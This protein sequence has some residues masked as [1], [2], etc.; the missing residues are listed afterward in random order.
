MLTPERRRAGPRCAPCARLLASA[1]AARDPRPVRARRPRRATDV[2][3]PEGDVRAF[4]EQAP[5]AR[6]RCPRRA[7]CSAAWDPANR[8]IRKV[9]RGD[10]DADDRARRGQAPLRRRAPPAAAARLAR[11][12]ALL[13]LGALGLW[14]RLP[15]ASRVAR[16]PGVPRRAPRVAARVPL[17]RARGDRGRRARRRCRS[18]SARRRRSS[19]AATRT[20]ATSA[21]PTTSRSSPRAAGRCSRSGSFYLDAA[22]HASSGRSCNVALPRRA[23][24]SRSAL[25]LSRPTLRLKRASTACSSSCPWAV[26]TYVTAL[27]WKGMFHRQFGAVNARPRV[28]ALGRTSSPSRG[29]RSFSTA[30]AANVAT[31]VW[32]GFPFMM[33]VTLG[34][35]TSIPKDVLEAAEV[36]GATRWQRFRLVTLPLLRPDAAARR[37]A[38]RGLD[39]QHVQRRLPRLGRRA[40]RHDRHP[41]ERGLPLGL[42]ARRAV[43]LRRGLRGAHLPPPRRRSTRCSA[44][45]AARASRRA[46][47]ER[48][49]DERPIASP[50]ES[51]ARAR[52]ARRSP[53]CFALYP[54]LWVVSLALL[55]ARC[56]ARPG[57][58]RAR[59]DAVARHLVAVVDARLRDGRTAGSS[60]RQLANSLVVSLATARRRRRDRRRPPRTRS[61]ASGSSARSAGV[62]ALLATQMFPTVASAVPLYLL[63]DALHLLDSRTGLV[64]VLRVDRGAVRDLPAARRVRGDPGRPRGGGDGRRRDALRGLPARGAPRGAPG[65]RG[66]RAL[67]LHERVERVHPRRDAARRARRRSRCRSC[68][69]ATS[70]STTR[71]WGRFAAGAI[72]VSVPVMALFYVAQRQLV[73]RAHGGRREGVEVRGR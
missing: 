41:R 44:R 24:A 21:S 26:P 58:A 23:S 56:A 18:S 22:R 72:L 32:L 47:R 50:L 14:A 25:V 67:R 35:L 69:S 71:A 37:R 4:A 59:S 9:L 64:L 13:V 65:D 39:V 46:P 33:V 68:S 2:I 8:A 5:D 6:S 34:A 19:P 20:R 60:A 40:R 62:R 43:R 48:R 38:R 66:D 73:A 49:H 36:D 12:A 7:R 10:A 54:V 57:A 1:E 53:S 3:M 17:R 28:D 42:H 27:A 30:F 29:S 16:E 61:R 70:A 45:G 15:L 51:L 52:R 63:L 11:A 31:N 55:R